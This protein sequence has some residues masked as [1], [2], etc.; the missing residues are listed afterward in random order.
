MQLSI[1]LVVGLLLAVASAVTMIACQVPSVIYLQR[2]AS[3]LVEQAAHVTTLRTSTFIE[4]RLQRMMSA[5]N[6]AHRAASRQDILSVDALL[7]WVGRVVEREDFGAGIFDESGR[8]IYLDAQPT[9]LTPKLPGCV[10]VANLTEPESVD[11]NQ[12]GRVS[13]ARTVERRL[14]RRT[15][16]GRCEGDAAVGEAC[17]V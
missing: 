8:G 15:N 13:G 12:L 3:G 7:L 5:C 16:R 6:V 14:A 2:D 10:Y 1:K 4:E 9:A 17:P 11:Y